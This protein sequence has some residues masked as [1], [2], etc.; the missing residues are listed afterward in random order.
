M[1]VA[2]SNAFCPAVVQTEPTKRTLLALEGALAY[3]R[4]SLVTAFQDVMYRRWTSRSPTAPI[5]PR[6]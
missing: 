6:G 5:R 3:L 4:D 1:N 2:T